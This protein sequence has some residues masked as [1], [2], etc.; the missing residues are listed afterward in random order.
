MWD[1]LAEARVTLARDMLVLVVDDDELVR[2]VIVEMLEDLA[3]TVVE[4]GSGHQ[5]LQAI[6]NR[7]DLD[8]VISDVNMPGMDGLA[9]MAEVR[10][11]RP[12]LPV[13]LMSGRPYAGP[14]DLFLQKPFTLSALVDC[15]VRSAAEGAWAGH[16]G[17]SPAE[18]AAERPRG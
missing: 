11:L 10:A 12:A 1:L 17:R 4:A 18:P 3:V 13:I 14:V 5:A 6:R 2:P 9:L 8:L 7:P 15:I 16:C